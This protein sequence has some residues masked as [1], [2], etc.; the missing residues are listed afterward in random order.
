MTMEKQNL[1]TLKGRGGYYDLLKCTKCGHKE[2]Y[3][4]VQRP[5]YCP[6]C[7]DGKKPPDVWGGWA[8]PNSENRL[9]KSLVCQF[10]QTSVIEVPKEGHA[11]SQYWAFQRSADE[12][13]YC[14]PNGCLEDGSFIF[15]KPVNPATKKFHRPKT[16][17]KVS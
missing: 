17:A 8:R 3:Y 4:G 13:L 9:S 11:N 10:C 6:K 12:I 5:G 1:V 14:C 7:G 2:K 15:K 16:E